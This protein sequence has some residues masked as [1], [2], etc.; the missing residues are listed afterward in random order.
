MQFKSEY[1]RILMNMKANWVIGSL[2][3]PSINMLCDPISLALHRVALRRMG[4][5]GYRKGDAI[6][7]P[8]YHK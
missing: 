7:A 6:Q 3:N 2:N 5:D 1:V 8:R 4:I